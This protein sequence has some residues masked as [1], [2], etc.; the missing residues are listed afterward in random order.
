MHWNHLKFYSHTDS[1]RRL[2]FGPEFC[3]SNNLLLTPSKSNRKI[4]GCLC[5]L[6]PLTSFHPLS[7]ANPFTKDTQSRGRNITYINPKKEMSRRGETYISA[8]VLARPL[9]T[10]LF[11]FAQ[12]LLETS[13]YLLFL[14]RDVVT[15]QKPFKNSEPE[16]ESD[17]YDLF[18]RCTVLAG[19]KSWQM[20]L[21]GGCGGWGGGREG[22]HMVAL[23]LLAEWIFLLKVPHIFSVSQSLPVI[24]FI[25]LSSSFLSPPNKSPYQ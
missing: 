20:L 4:L 12:V 7:L 16:P 23:H 8:Q 22:G 21:F 9:T 1:C 2:E 6:H 14:H 5:F 18:S 19:N 3:I 17:T 10:T 15:S 13:L 11:C 24:L 25:S